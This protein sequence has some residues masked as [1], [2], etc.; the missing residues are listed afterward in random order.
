MAQGGRSDNLQRGK[1]GSTGIQ[2]DLIASKAKWVRSS[3][4]PLGI[5][6]IPFWTV[7]P[8]EMYSK[9]IAFVN[10]FYFRFSLRAAH[11]P[12]GLAIWMHISSATRM[13]GSPPRLQPN[14]SGLAAADE[15]VRVLTGQASR[16]PVNPE[17]LQAGRETVLV[18]RH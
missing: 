8:G 9:R 12:E 11:L 10:L 15:L 3:F 14:W 7:T 13:S 5:S 18:D 1:V 4:L 2:F 16:Y 6:A 17:A